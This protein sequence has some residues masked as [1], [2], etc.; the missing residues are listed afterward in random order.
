MRHQHEKEKRRDRLR[1]VGRPR[2]V[3][4]WKRESRQDRCVLCRF[5][6]M[7][8]RK[9]RASVASASL[10]RWYVVT[11]CGCL[12]NS[13][14]IRWC[15]SFCVVVFAVLL[16]AHVDGSNSHSTHVLDHTSCVSR[17]LVRFRRMWVI[18]TMTGLSPW[19]R[20]CSTT[21]KFSTRLH[22]WTLRSLCLNA[23]QH[24]FKIG[25]KFSPKVIHRVFSAASGAMYERTGTASEIDSFGVFGDSQ[26]CRTYSKKWK[27]RHWQ[28]K[29]W[30]AIGM[31]VEK[32]QMTMGPDD[33]DP[34]MKSSVWHFTEVCN[35]FSR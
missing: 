23:V 13:S 14:A 9:R 28:T 10:I 30:T 15:V 12:F 21:R 31:D 16:R 4:D 18:A 34:R 33:S 3:N 35:K 7:S 29:D 26:N 25:L 32:K 11:L 22:I 5:G 2:T 6:V 24:V 17:A 1:I 8:K 19:T 27:T 20:T